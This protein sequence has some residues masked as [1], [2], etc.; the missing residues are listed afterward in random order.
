ME[1]FLKVFDSRI[2]MEVIPKLNEVMKSE[3]WIGARS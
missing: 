3:P 1:D 2:D